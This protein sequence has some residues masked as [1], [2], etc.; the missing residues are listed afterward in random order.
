MTI[1]YTVLHN[2]STHQD[3]MCDCNWANGICNT[4]L[5]Y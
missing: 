2:I 5:A 3:N 1:L 4:H